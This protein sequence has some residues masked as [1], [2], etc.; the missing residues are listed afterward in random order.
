[1]NK[2]N[3]KTRKHFSNKIKRSVLLEYVKGKK[4]NEIFAELGINFTRDK[5]YASKLVNK[6]KKELYK[7]INILSLDFVN[8]DENYSEKEINTIGRDDEI[9]NILDKLLT[10]NNKK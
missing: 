9:D 5:K 3:K 6:W 8:I 2:E 7:N 10:K 1:M 4:P